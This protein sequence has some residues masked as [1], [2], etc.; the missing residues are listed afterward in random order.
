[1]SAAN[2]AV[3]ANKT[4]TAANVCALICA[5][6]KGTRAGFNKNKLLKDVLGIP[7]LE[8]TIA[9]F[10]AAGIS[11]IVVAAAKEDF[12]EIAP[13]C[14]KYGATLCE[15]GATRF[16]SVYSGLQ[17][18]KKAKSEIVLIHDGARPF[19]SAET[20]A[21]CI[22]SVKTY[23]S[24][25]CAVPATDTLAA[26]NENGEIESYPVRAKTYR[27]QTPQGFYLAEIRA[28]YD[29][30]IQNGETDFTDDSSVYA[31]YIRAPKLCAGEEKN[32]KLTYAEDFRKAFARVGIGVDTHAFGRAQNYIV[33]GGVQVPSES[34][35]IAHSD[36][37]VLCHAV[38][39]ALLSA[40]GLKDIGHYFPDTSAEW[41]NAD[42]MKMLAKVLSLVRGQGFRPV[43]LSAAI[44]AEK[45]RLAKYIGAIKKSLAG[46][47]NLPETAVGIS[48]GTNEK[49]GYIGE[50][51]GITANAAVLLEQI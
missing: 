1:M 26:A 31:K 28:A 23:K 9:A 45:P 24:G 51:K 10:A 19:V 43:N 25:V 34:G 36:G 49:L 44:Q 12:P 27:I 8:R 3:T 38:M 5:G 6:G 50:G 15:G 13:L 35:L 29:Q 37:D 14:R 47:L 4:E 11:E 2:D 46:A 32:I 22:Q 18:A 41:E 42:S 16:L 30:A 39:D 17:Q 40:T 33:L 48:A 20:V 7:V 21:A